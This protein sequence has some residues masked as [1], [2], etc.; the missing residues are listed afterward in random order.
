MKTDS[1]RA[2]ASSAIILRRWYFSVEDFDDNL[3]YLGPDGESIDKDEAKRHPF[4]G[5]TRAAED[6]G[7]RRAN[8]WEEREDTC[9]ANFTRHSMGKT[10]NDKAVPTEG[11]EKKL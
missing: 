10:Q 7:E 1:I 4:I 8:R 5:D 3:E 9:A 11:G 2:V 6:E